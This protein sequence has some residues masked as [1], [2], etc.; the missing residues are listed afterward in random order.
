MSSL[1]NSA[2]SLIARKGRSV[3]LAKLGASTYNTAT[4]VASASSTNYTFNALVL[5]Y[6]NRERDGTLI[7]AGDRKIVLTGKGAGATPEVGDTVT[8]GSITF[9]LVDV[10]VV[11]ENTDNLIFTC[12]GRR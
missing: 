8:V 11:V 7:Q 12:Q 9:K 1:Q 4:G 6:S 3:T 2:A 5:A 10:Q